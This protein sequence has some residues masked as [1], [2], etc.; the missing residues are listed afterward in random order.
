VEEAGSTPDEAAI[1]IGG[2]MFCVSSPEVKWSGSGP[3]NDP[4]TWQSVRL[5]VSWERLEL[6]QTKAGV[7]IVVDGRSLLVV[8]PAA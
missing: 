3:I 7:D 2:R 8:R 6:Q 1:D 5:P 4:T